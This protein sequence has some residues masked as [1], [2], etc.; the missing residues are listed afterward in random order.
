MDE[1]TV[2]AA[3]RRYW[4][5]ART[6]SDKAHEL[7]HDDAVLDFPQSKERFVGMENFK[8][9]RKKYPS[10]LEFNI[11]RVRGS[12]DV[13]VTENTIRY[14]DGP[15]NFACSILEFRG[16]KIARETIYIGQGWDAP[17]WRAPWRAA[18]S[19]EPTGN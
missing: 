9:W 17:E 16:E 2:R 8:A 11:Q 3:L 19:D 10:K 6:D 18:W 4:Q 7:Y 13:W 1:A 12:G 14:D 5:Y 15:L